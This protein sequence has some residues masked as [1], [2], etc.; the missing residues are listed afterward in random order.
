[1]TIPVVCLRCHKEYKRIPVNPATPPDAES[2]GYCP[3][4]TPVVKAEFDRELA[5]LLH[6]DLVVSVCK[7]SSPH[8]DPHRDGLD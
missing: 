2:S 1:M 5:S 8:A 7:P 4:C 6:H 3:A